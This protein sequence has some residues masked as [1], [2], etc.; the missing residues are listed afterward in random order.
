MTSNRVGH[1]I[2]VPVRPQ[3]QELT[4]LRFADDIV[5]VA[6]SRRDI[7]MMLGHL[8]RASSKFGLRIHF[9]KTKIMTRNTLAKGAKHV[10]VE[11]QLVDIVDEEAFEKYL[12]CKLSFE[13]GMGTELANRTAAGWAAFHK[14]KGELCNKSYKLR[15]RLRLFDA[16]VTPKV[17]YGC[18]AWALTKQQESHLKTTQRRTL[19]YVLQIFRCKDSMGQL[20]EW[21]EYMK[22]SA[23]A[24]GSKR[25]AHRIDDW[26]QTYRR[27]KWRFAGKTARQTDDRWS[28]WLLAWVPDNGNGRCVGR[29]RTRYTDEFVEYLG[30]GWLE[31]ASD[32]DLRATLEHGFVHRVW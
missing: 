23:H 9:G 30:G 19:R 1:P 14:H 29:P 7:K 32:S 31:V 3:G 25:Q 13:G 27:R 5:F 10:T 15:D 20:E 11:N 26:V 8:A 21:V 24:V 6:Q 2:G 16:V 4:N 22:R 28:R 12:G 18:G 17:L